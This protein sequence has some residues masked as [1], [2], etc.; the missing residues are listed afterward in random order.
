M[1][2]GSSSS[3][4]VK[5]RACAFLDTDQFVELGMQREIIPAVGPLN[6]QRHHED[7]EGRDRIPLEGGRAEGEPKRRV[8][9]DKKKGGGVSRR[10]PDR[11]GPVIFDPDSF[12][13]M[14]YPLDQEEKKSPA[15]GGGF[16]LTT[17]ILS[18]AAGSEE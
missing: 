5:F 8:D 13:V 14:T 3:S 18:E 11:G 15:T 17:P 9:N 4:C 12:S 1:T 2:S 7:C 16:S 10:L 6:E